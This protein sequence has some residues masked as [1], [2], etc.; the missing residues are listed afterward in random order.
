MYKID[1][2][3]GKI[4]EARREGEEYVTREKIEEETFKKMKGVKIE[5]EE[6]FLKEMKGARVEGLREEGGE[7]RFKLVEL[8]K[9]ERKEMNRKKNMKYHNEW[10]K[11][12]YD[13]VSLA[14]PKGTKERILATGSTVSGF[15]VEAVRVMLEA[16]EGE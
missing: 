16:N 9:E 11:S 12:N 6:G 1:L 8:T 3:N 10:I 15:I 13:R 5:T 4:L 14:L 2:G 7:W